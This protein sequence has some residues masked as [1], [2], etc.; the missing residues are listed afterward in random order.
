MKNNN[1]GLFDVTM[2]SYDRAEFCALVGLYILDQLGSQYNKEND[3]FAVFENV[4]GP[5]A[6]GIKKNIQKFFMG[7]ASKLSSRGT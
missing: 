4:T 2:G 5:Q 1:D 6:E 7:P 3:G